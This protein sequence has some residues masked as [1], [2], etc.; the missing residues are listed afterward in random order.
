MAL[1]NIS[2]TKEKILIFDVFPKIN[3]F[4]KITG[5]QGA[6][7]TI[8]SRFLLAYGEL[9]DTIEIK[10]GSKFSLKG[11]FDC[12]E[13]DNLIYK[14]II[15]LKKYLSSQKIPS[16]MLECLCLEVEKKIPKGAG[17]GGGSADAGMCLV[18]INEFFNLGLDKKQLQ[19]IGAKIGSDVAFFVSQYTSANVYGR[20]EVICPYN[21]ESYRFEIFTPNVFCD[22][23]KV[24][25]EYDKNTKKSKQEGLKNLEKTPTSEILSSYERKE[26]ND[27][28]LPAI[29]AY[30]KL[31]KIE[32]DLGKEWYF[33]GSGSSF[34]KLKD[35]K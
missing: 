23:K 11:D 27:L 14:A 2:S 26:L 32:K 19:N 31:A 1:A 25:L 18:K 24:Y 20:G 30:P 21:E 7:H 17:L 10:S 22:T 8:S 29:N 34:F 33:S 12:E 5:L 15:E 3:V 6:Y 35:T 16:T 28:L 4:L 13:K 9:K